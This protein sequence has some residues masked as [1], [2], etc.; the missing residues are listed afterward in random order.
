MAYLP[1]R[2]LEPGTID[3][4]RKNIGP[5]DAQEAAAMQ[6]ILGGEVLREKLNLGTRFHPQNFR[7]N[8]YICRN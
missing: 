2:T 4:T 8:E 7:K 5:I 3:K 1:K 6:K